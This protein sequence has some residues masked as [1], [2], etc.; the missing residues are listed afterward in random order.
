MTEAAIPRACAEAAHRAGRAIRTLVH[1]MPPAERGGPTRSLMKPAG[2]YGARHVD[3]EA[4][5]V[6]LAHL[7]GLSS[8]TGVGI[9]LLLDSGAGAVHHLGRADGA[10]IVA[11]MDVIDGTVKVAG[12]G[13]PVADRVRLANDGGWAAAF[14]FTRPTRKRLDELLLADFET[15]VVVDGN[16]TLYRTYPGD[17]VALPGA[18]GVVTVE[19]ADGGERR[20]FTTT[21]DDLGQLWV[22]LDVFQAYDLASRR[23][24]DD[25]VGAEL[26]RLL[27]DRHGGGA[28]DVL[29]QYANLSAL[30]RLLLGW[31]E[32][33]VWVE[34]QGAAF[35]VVNENLPN[36][37][38]AVPIVAGAGGVSVDFDGRPLAAR[39][40]ADGRTSVIHAANEV[41]CRRLVAL[42]AAARVRAGAPA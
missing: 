29:R 21:A 30:T 22:S 36:L 24:R 33:P 6:G 38:P 16:P 12:L 26:H 4:E 28:F 39:R 20:V 40:L 34:S 35:V 27:A 3:T 1:A 8:A 7:E 14:A 32:P 25:A 41:L 10:R 5:A 42:V 2:G 9:D 19:A 15:A 37:I 17:V 11:S 18:G 23:D 13:P 31:R